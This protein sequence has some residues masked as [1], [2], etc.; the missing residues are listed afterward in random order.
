[1]RETE[2]CQRVNPVTSNLVSLLVTLR[3]KDTTKPKSWRIKNLLL[4]TSKENTLP[5]SSVFPKSKIV[6]FQVKGMCIFMKRLEKI[7][8]RIG[9]TVNRVH[10][11][12]D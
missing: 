12:V 5:Q 6:K 9:G 8:Q 10:T 2:L 11:S 7:Q 4:A 1:M 3:P